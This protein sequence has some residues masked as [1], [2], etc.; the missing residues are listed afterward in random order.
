MESVAF[1]VTV[2]EVLSKGRGKFRNTLIVGLAKCDRIF[3][4]PPLQK[5]INNNYYDDK[6]TLPMKSTP[7]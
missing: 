5:I 3:L 7:G 4:F 6:V 1:A 2:M